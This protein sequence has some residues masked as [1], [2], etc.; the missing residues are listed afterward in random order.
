MNQYCVGIDVGGTTVKCG[1][2][3]YNGLLLDKWEVPS[4]KAENGRY[5]LPDVADELKKHLSEKTIEEEDIADRDRRAG[6]GRAKRI[7][8]YLRESGLGG[9][10]AREGAQG[11]HGREDSLRLRE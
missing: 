5:I 7:C 2:F 11:A 10:L 3:T 8:A 9:P 6:A 4:R 1:I